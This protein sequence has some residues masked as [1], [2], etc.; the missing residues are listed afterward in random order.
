MASDTDI[1]PK[2]LT[3]SSYHTDFSVAYLLIDK[4]IVANRF[5]L[6]YKDTKKGTAQSTVLH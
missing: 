5:Y 3:V 1:T 6:P 4:I 2:L